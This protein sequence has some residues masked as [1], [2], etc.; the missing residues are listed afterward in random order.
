MK[1]LL[2]QNKIFKN[3]KKIAISLV[4][5]FGL[6]LIGIKIF[7]SRVTAQVVPVI[8]HEFDLAFGTVFPGEELKG[9]FE[10]HYVE[11]Y[12]QEGVNYK[13]IKQLKPLPDGSGFYKD[14]CPFLTP[15]KVVEGAE[16]D[17]PDSAYVGETDLSDTW[18]IYFKVPAI[19][20]HVSQDHTGGVVTEDGDYG[21]DVSIDIPE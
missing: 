14:L 11:D 2:L 10:V 15:I 6:I 3:P 5:I 20:G 12:P 9:N 7:S 18:I 21:C 8:V 4:I 13:I 17:N 16:T 1:L 19:V